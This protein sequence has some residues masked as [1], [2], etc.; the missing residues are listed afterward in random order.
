MA[1][2]TGRNVAAAAAGVKEVAVAGTQLVEVGMGRPR[3]NPP[4]AREL[5]LKLQLVH[6]VVSQLDE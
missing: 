4:A 6:E 5:R 3:M 1:K 2:V